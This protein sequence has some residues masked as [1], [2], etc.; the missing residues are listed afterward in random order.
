[1][2]DSRT[3]ISM[4][5]CECMYNALVALLAFRKLTNAEVSEDTRAAAL[6]ARAV[7]GAFPPAL[8]FFG[9]TFSTTDILHANFFHHTSS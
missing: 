1:V 3:P 5:V 6:G 8:N 2:R 9:S 4:Y 7:R